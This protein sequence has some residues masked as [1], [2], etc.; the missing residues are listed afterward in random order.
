MQF[1][2]VKIKTAENT[3]EYLITNLPYSFTIEENKKKRTEE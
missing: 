1:R 3:Y 2:V